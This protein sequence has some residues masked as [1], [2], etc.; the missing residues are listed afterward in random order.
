[1]VLPRSGCGLLHKVSWPWRSLEPWTVLGGGNS[2]CSHSVLNPHGLSHRN[3]LAHLQTKRARWVFQAYFQRVHGSSLATWP[4]STSRSFQ[5][6]PHYEGKCAFVSWVMARRKGNGMM[7][8]PVPALLPKCSQGRDRGSKVQLTWEVS[9]RS[10]GSKRFSPTEHPF[11]Q[12]K[13]TK[14]TWGK[15]WTVLSEAPRAASCDEGHHA[16]ATHSTPALPHSSSSGPG[17]LRTVINTLKK[18]N[19]PQMNHFLRV[20]AVARRKKGHQVSF[21]MLHKTIVSC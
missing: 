3:M 5:W 7:S 19:H 12:E 15:G 9:K 8:G 20:K 17:L 2:L 14:H 13:P 18:K 6:K 10:F 16:V 1:M 11:S 4:A 21:P